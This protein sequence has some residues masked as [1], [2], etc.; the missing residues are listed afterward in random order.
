MNSY[1]IIQK[2]L[3]PYTVVANTLAEAL[4]SLMK[5]EER[6]PVIATTLKQEGLIVSSVMPKWSVIVSPAS[7]TSFVYPVSGEGENVSIVAVEKGNETFD[8]WEING[9][10][11][12]D[13]QILSYTIKEN[14]TITA[15]FSTATTDELAEAVLDYLYY[16]NGKKV[17]TDATT[18]M[19]GG[20][21]EGMT[22]VSLTINDTTLV[23][24]VALNN[25]VT[26][27]LEDEW[28]RYTTGQ[29]T[30]TFNG[31]TEGTLFAATSWTLNSSSGVTFTGGKVECIFVYDNLTAGLDTPLR[32]T[33]DLTGGTATVN[34]E[35][36]EQ[37]AETIDQSKFTSGTVTVNG[38]TFI[39]G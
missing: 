29:A 30:L 14:T 15:V 33:I 19:K 9:E 3:R 31:T 27:Y 36:L 34:E 37:I 11:I 12:S 4:N 39:G 2:G 28:Q 6:H 21:V 8:H 24:T 23:G 26:N 10:T 35:D 13:N 38:I 22:G 1:R 20:S 16:L 17:L 7:A 32:F 5:P 25:W 18:T